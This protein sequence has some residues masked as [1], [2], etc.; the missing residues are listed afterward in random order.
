MPA[1][2]RRKIE[3]AARALLLR[4]RAVAAQPRTT[5][6]KARANRLDDAGLAARDFT[7]AGRSEGGGAANSQNMEPD[8]RQRRGGQ[9][10]PRP[11]E[12]WTAAPAPAM[13]DVWALWNPRG[14]CP[15]PPELRGGALLRYQTTH[16][17]PPPSL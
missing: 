6:P 3:L 11:S 10:A 7:L 2:E 14:R 15:A 1:G 16:H 12:R 9:R 4:G 17:S 5:Y 8:G 13:A